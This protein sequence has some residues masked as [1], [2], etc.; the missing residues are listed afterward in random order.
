MLFPRAV[1]F[2]LGG[3][4]VSLSGWD[5]EADLRWRFSYQALVT[6]HPNGGWPS[7]EVYI[8]AMRG[9]E[10]AHW[11]RVVNEQWSG[12]PSGLLGDGFRRL[13]LQVGEKELLAALD[14]YAQAT[15]GWATPFSDA[16]ETLS[17]L[18]REGYRLGLLSNTWWAAQ[19]HNDHLALHQLN[20]MLDAVVYTSDLPYSKPHPQTFLEIA[21]R[22]GVEPQSCVMVGDMVIDDISGALA[23]GMHAGD[24]EAQ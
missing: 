19:W 4:L 3:T 23:L 7:C 6:R 21:A 24:L 13:G 15:A 22:L 8:G 5:S 2:D 18:R 17:I 11:Q 20:K 9:A 10:A 14:G 16:H 1:I 12:P